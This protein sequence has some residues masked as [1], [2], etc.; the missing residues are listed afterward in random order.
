MKSANA[1]AILDGDEANAVSLDGNFENGWGNWLYLD[2][3]GAFEDLEYDTEYTLGVYMMEFS[4]TYSRNK[5]SRSRRAGF[6]SCIC[7]S[8]RN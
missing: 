6:L 4:R 5:N 2:D 1:I 7:I 3:N 8:K